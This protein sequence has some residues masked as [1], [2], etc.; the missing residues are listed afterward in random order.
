[1]HESMVV[2]PHP[3]LRQRPN[4]E[5]SPDWSVAV[6][7]P[8]ASH[9]TVKRRSKFGVQIHYLSQVAKD[10]EVRSRFAGA[11]ALNI[12]LPHEERSCEQ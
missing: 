3:S 5:K 2:L 1:M 7:A 11:L 4:S 8:K 10:F 9:V 12:R 6:V